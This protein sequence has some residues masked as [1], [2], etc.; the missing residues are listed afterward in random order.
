MVESADLMCFDNR[1][2]NQGRDENRTK[3]N[4]WSQAEVKLKRKITKTEQ[5]IKNA[6][7]I[8]TINYPGKFS[9]TIQR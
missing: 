5:S 7:K 8:T 4:I 2:N 1:Y 9:R 3:A 6:R